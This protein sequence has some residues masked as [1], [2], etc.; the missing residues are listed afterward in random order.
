MHANYVRITV[1]GPENRLCPAYRGGL[2]ARIGAGPAG[3]GC[4]GA[5]DRFEDLA[6][7]LEA[8][9]ER[10]A[11]FVFGHSGGAILS[12]EAAMP[13]LPMRRL[14]VNEPPYI[15]VLPQPA[16]VVA[17][18][19]G[20]DLVRP[21]R[22]SRSVPISAPKATGTI[23]SVSQGLASSR[24]PPLAACRPMRASHVVPNPTS[25]PEAA[26]ITSPR[27]ATRTAS[28]RRTT[29]RI[30]PPMPRSSAFAAPSPNHTIHCA[31]GFIV[32]RSANVP[33][34]VTMLRLRHPHKRQTAWPVRLFIDGLVR[35]I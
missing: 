33:I 11:A 34:P 26:D 2:R 27:M 4:H 8:V 21:Q 16:D 12:L 15:V 3:K 19:R 6:A 5:P 31:I 14:A 32:E 18:Y 30:T 1:A 13:G 29:T 28:T 23:P 7:V 10:S 35:E 22:A 20:S 24:R 25:N 17:C 9:S